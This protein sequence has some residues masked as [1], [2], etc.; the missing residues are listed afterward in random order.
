MPT[1]VVV[2]LEP[3]ADRTCRMSQAFETLAMDTL[4]F[5]RLDQ[6]LH[7]AV[8]LRTIRR[9]ELPAQTLAFDQGRVLP[10]SKDKTIVA[11][12]REWLVGFARCANACNQACSKAEAVA[13]PIRRPAPKSGQLP[14]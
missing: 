8:L 5:Q 4:L 3:V 10:S 12:N 7:L 1:P 11:T 2:E 9:K 14:I 13:V 6:A